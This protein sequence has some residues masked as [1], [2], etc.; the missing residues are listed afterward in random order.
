MKRLV[1]GNKVWSAPEI[2]KA[3]YQSQDDVGRS[4][5]RIAPLSSENT[6]SLPRHNTVLTAKGY[7]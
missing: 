4:D 7:L 2:T 3:H 5:L 1:Y 6:T